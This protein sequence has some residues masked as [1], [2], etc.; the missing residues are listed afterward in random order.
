MKTYLF[1]MYVVDSWL[2]YTN[3]T[4]DKLHPEPELDQQEFYCV[5]SQKLIKRVR[6][7]QSCGGVNRAQKSIQKHQWS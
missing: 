6:P 7:T 1:G 5:L 2:M 3:A 4:T